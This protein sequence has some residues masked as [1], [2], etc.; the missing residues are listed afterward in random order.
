[1]YIYIQVKSVYDNQSKVVVLEM[2]LPYKA[3]S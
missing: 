2:W 3:P 1:M